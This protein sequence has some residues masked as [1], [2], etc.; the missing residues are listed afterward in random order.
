MTLMTGEF[1]TINGTNQSYQI[2]TTLITQNE[3]DSTW[4]HLNIYSFSDSISSNGSS[5]IKLPLPSVQAMVLLLFA[6]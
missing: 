3:G 2:V 4:G 1:Y 5:L 6:M